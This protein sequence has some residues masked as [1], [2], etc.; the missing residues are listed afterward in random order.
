MK[1]FAG[2]R[3]NFGEGTQSV[4]RDRRRIRADD[5]TWQ[6]LCGGNCIHR[7]AP[8]SVRVEG[9]GEVVT[10]PGRVTSA[11]SAIHRKRRP[12][13]RVRDDIHSHIICT[14]RA[15]WYASSLQVRCTRTRMLSSGP[16]TMGPLRASGFTLVCGDDRRRPFAAVLQ[17]RGGPLLFSALA[18]FRNF[19]NQ[20]TTAGAPRVRRENL[21][22]CFII[23]I[24]FSVLPHPFFLWRCN[25]EDPPTDCRLVSAV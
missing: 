24:K 1:G 20:S 14:V 11:A 7:L 8:G 23:V 9:P 22:P 5:H 2:D 17:A 4:E 21:P 18:R 3:N 6:T 19:P 15:R 13:A 12:A 16:S 10:G 25:Y